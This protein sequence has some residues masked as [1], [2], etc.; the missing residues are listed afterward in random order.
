MYLLG[1]VKL[2][3]HLA[4]LAHKIFST[5]SDICLKFM[6]LAAIKQAGLYTYIFFII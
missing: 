6:L 5:A 1:L 2:I 3:D 4:H